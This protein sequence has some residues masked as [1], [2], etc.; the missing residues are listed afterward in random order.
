MGR[1]ELRSA[2]TFLYIARKLRRHS[3]PGRVG[4]NRERRV[5]AE[6]FLLN[7]SISR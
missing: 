1:N 5:G 4:G 3:F 6:R 7:C 2:E